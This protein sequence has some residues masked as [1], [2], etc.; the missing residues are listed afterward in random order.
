MI[1][2]LINAASNAI[3]TY[4]RR[5]FKANTYTD[6]KDGTGNT[7]L[8]LKNYPI[9]SITSLK[10]YDSLVTD[11]TFEGDNG[12]VYRKSGWPLDEKN[13]EINYT[14]GYDVIPD[15][16]ELACIYLIKSLINEEQNKQSER[17]G[18]YSVTYVVT[19]S[20]MPRVCKS[21]LDPYRGDII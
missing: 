3:E 15:D 8:I 7:K 19:E 16:I 4:C 2:I 21:L 5:T 18:D 10:I 6:I 14:S 11:F 9:K 20:N 12:I 13:I 17:I 1:E